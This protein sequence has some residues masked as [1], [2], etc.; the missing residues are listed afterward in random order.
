[1]LLV[2]ALLSAGSARA[3]FLLVADQRVVTAGDMLEISLI[4]TNDSGER[5]L[6]VELPAHITL[7][8]RGM[9]NAPDIVL[10]P[11]A[12]PSMQASVGPGGFLRVRYSGRLP[13][14]LTGNL[15]LDAP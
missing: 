12:M 1:M 7:R 14:G 10:S 3:E 2:L 9:A 13:Q 8:V 4:V 6:P 5:A 11:A 15:V